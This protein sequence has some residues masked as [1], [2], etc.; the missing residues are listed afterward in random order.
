MV[1]APLTAWDGGL[2]LP[3]E[4]LSRHRNPR[5]APVVAAPVAEV[6]VAE[7]RHEFTEH[8]VAP[9]VEPISEPTSTPVTEAIFDVTGEPVPEAATEPSFDATGHLTVP[10][11]T[12]E[13]LVVAPA[14]AAEYEPTDAD[15]ASYRIDPIT[16]SAYR[17]PSV[18]V[19][20]DVQ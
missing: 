4:T 12:T 18:A 1:E 5:P 3:G 8:H 17:Q 14:P 11:A 16:P 19:P 9:L 6:A 10:A 15:S 7:T 13:E 2:Q 20:E